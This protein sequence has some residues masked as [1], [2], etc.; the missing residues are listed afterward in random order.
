MAA[1]VLSDDPGNEQLYTHEQFQAQA[2]PC[3]AARG[4]RELTGQVMVFSDGQPLRKQFW[5]PGL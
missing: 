4:A 1:M 3:H 5:A 2:P